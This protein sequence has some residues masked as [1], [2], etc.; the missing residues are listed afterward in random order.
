[1][2]ERHA[3]VGE[4]DTPSPPLAP[5]CSHA[6]QE[7]GYNKASAGSRYFSWLAAQLNGSRG[8]P[9]PNQR[10]KRL[11]SPLGHRL[12]TSATAPACETVPERS[13]ET[14][15]EHRYHDKECAAD[16]DYTDVESTHRRR[17]LVLVLTVLGLAIAGVAGALGFR[18]PYSGFRRHSS[19]RGTRSRLC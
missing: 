4:Q 6:V 9:T 16:Q 8:E 10:M 1:M 2:N 15:D 3:Y 19:A 14:A 7:H 13:Y 18:A 17:S 11:S 5:S 12:P